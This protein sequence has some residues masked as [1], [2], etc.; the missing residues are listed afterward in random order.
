MVSDRVR[1]NL[2][3]AHR[4]HAGHARRV[5]TG[6]GDVFRTCAYRM[7]TPPHR[8]PAGRLRRAGG[9]AARV[10]ALPDSGAPPQIERRQPSL[11]PAAGY[12]AGDHR[13]DR[14]QDTPLW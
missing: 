6:T 2:R 1:R 8:A 4:V 14:T 9:L 3:P 11:A 10:V 12:A 13:P 7:D 5:S